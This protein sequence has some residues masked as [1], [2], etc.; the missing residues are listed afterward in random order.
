MIHFKNLMLS[1]T[2]TQLLRFFMVGISSVLTDL[3]IYK[4]LLFFLPISLAK[5]IGFLAGTLVSYQANRTW[6]FAAGSINFQQAIRFYSI[7]GT[8][9]CINV[10]I[11]A[12]IITAFPHES[13][14]AVNLAFLLAT[15]AS[16]TFNF[17]GMKYFVFKSRRK[18]LKIRL[19]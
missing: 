1:H 8:S 14:L 19:K 5:G 9:L 4:T 17:L 18:L 15:A 6:T 13:S 7:Y 11:N 3:L 10:A 2:Q 12:L 16:A